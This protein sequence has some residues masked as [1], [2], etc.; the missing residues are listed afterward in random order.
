MSLSV[1]E[2]DLADAGQMQPSGRLVECEERAEES[3]HASWPSM[4]ADSGCARPIP[5]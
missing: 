5:C 2:P 1:A 4:R 3:T